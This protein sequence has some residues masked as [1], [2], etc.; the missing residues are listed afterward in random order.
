VRLD[1]LEQLG[2]RRAGG[3]HLDDAHD[4]EQAAQGLADEKVVLRQYRPHRLAHVGPVMQDQ[5]RRE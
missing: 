1:G 5:R 2:E 3:Q 4:G